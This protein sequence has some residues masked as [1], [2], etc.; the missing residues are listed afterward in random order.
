MS[1]FLPVASTCEVPI[2][3]GLFFPIQS[4]FQALWHLYIPPLAT[5]ELL[6]L[7]HAMHRLREDWGT[8]LG[9]SS[10]VECLPLQSLLYTSLAC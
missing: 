7:W 9:M 1:L 8:L 10:R 6:G 5:K 2:L 3:C 4:P